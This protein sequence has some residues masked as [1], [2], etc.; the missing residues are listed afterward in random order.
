MCDHG[1]DYP[2]EGERRGGGVFSL[3]LAARMWRVCLD[4]RSTS[5]GGAV[6]R[7]PAKAARRANL[8]EESFL[9]PIAP[10]GGC[11]LCLSA[12]AGALWYSHAPGLQTSAALSPC[13]SVRRRVDRLAVSSA[14]PPFSHPLDVVHAWPI[15]RPACASVLLVLQSFEGF[16]NRCRPSPPGFEMA[17]AHLHLAAA[18]GGGGSL[19]SSGLAGPSSPCF[20]CP[21]QCLSS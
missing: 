2:G 11:R 8:P 19:A 9:Q 13:V 20:S 7:A 21:R 6:T 5:N 17:F 14:P 10:A 18:R 16:R 3:N 12:P 15:G 4:S 1:G